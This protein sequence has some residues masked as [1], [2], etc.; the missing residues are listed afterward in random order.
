MP[1]IGDPGKF[2]RGHGPPLQWFVVETTGAQEGDGPRGRSC[3]HDSSTWRFS[4]LGIGKAQG[5]H[6]PRAGPGVTVDACLTLGPCL[7]HA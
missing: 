4:G 5:G 7:P 2:D 1:A 3:P 6:C